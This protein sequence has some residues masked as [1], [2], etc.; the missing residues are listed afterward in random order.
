MFTIEFDTDRGEGITITTLDGKG[1]HDDVEVIL[2]DDDIYI[3][4]IDE[5]DGVQMIML[6]SQQFKD[7]VAAFNLPEGA[8][9]AS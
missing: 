1:R 2:Y 5:S 3:R 8:Y 7:I 4:Q 6:S 9:Y